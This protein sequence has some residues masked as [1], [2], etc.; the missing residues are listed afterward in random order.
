MSNKHQ[1]TFIIASGRDPLLFLTSVVS[2]RPSACTRTAENKITPLSPRQ[3]NASPALIGT[4]TRNCFPPISRWI[5]I[6]IIFRS[7]RARGGTGTGWGWAVK[8]TG[9]SPGTRS[10]AKLKSASD[11]GVEIEP[12]ID[13]DPSPFPD[14]HA[15]VE[16]A[17]RP[18]DF[19]VG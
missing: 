16:H 10:F 12:F 9:R 11:T 17:R 18:E 15:V 8:N 5:H 2:R 3:I 13:P 14:S 4:R 19:G 1:V 7:T 6:I